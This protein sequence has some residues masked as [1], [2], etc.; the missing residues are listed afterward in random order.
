[1]ELYFEARKATWRKHPKS[2]LPPPTYS[3]SIFLIIFLFHFPNTTSSS[4]TFSPP[5]NYLIDCGS[6]EQT[7]LSDGRNFKSERDAASLLSAEDEVQAS[8]EFSAIA[9][10]AKAAASLFSSSSIN[11]SIVPPSSLPLYATVRIFSHESTYSFHISQPGPHWIRL[12]FYPVPDPTH[13]LTAA[14]FKVSAGNYVLL[15][16]F[17]AMT[18]AFREF[19]VNITGDRFSL[20]FKPKKKTVAFVNAIE[21]VSA[22]NTLIS[23]SVPAVYPP[24]QSVTGA[25][26]HALRVSYRL[27]VGGPTLVSEND[28]LYRV[29][30]TDATFNKFKEGSRNVSVPPETVEYQK[31]KGLTP[32]IAPSLVYASAQEMQ[33][34]L[35]MEPNF[36]LSWI[37][38]VDQGYSY[39]IRLHFCDIVSAA[40]NT[41]FFNVYINEIMAMESVDLS[42]LTG[43][44]S[45]AYYKDFVLHSMNITNNKIMVQV[46]CNS[47]FHSGIRDAILN[48]LEI[49]KMSNSANSLDGLF[50]VSGKYKGPS[51]QKAMK[52][53]AAAGL[54]MSLTA[55]V[56]LCVACVSWKK[57]PKG[58]EKRKSFS[59][60]LLPLQSSYSRSS[61]NRSTLS[62]FG[63][64]RSKSGYSSYISPSTVLFGRVFS[65]AEL[66]VATQS[67][68]EKAVIGVGGFGKVYL[69]VLE[70]GTKLAVK[71][72]N[73]SSEQGI[74]EFRTEIEM[75]SKLRHRH[76]VSLIGFC[77]EQ[78]EM[79]LVYEY[80]S[81]GPFRDHL[82]GSNL[83]KLS[84][85]QRLEICI[86]AAR[87]L[88]YLHTGA[89]QGIIHRDVKTTNILLDENFVAKVADFGL[90]K[91]APSLDQTHVST[92]V[93]GSFGYLDPEY[94]RR[95]QLTEKS[96][97]Y[98]FG[99][100]LFEAL[101]ARPVI[102]PKLPR[103]QVSL[104]EWAMH[105]HRKG[106]IET[107]IDPFI[108]EQISSESLKKFVEAAEKCMAEYGVDRP[109]MGDV[110]WNLEYSLQLHE[111][112][113]VEDVDNIKGQ[114]LISMEKKLNGNEQGNKTISVV[115]DV[116]DVS[117]DHSSI[118]VDG[119]GDHIPMFSQ[120]GNFQGR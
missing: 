113:V 102:D 104:A 44:L 56:L 90:S 120:M 75:L 24:G 76:L 116:E 93:K 47:N 89:A 17:S 19:L 117:E 78:S 7:R 20:V 87:G 45:T 22:P 114:S 63:S 50:T 100:V 80:M 51:G 106:S 49:M 99:V 66:Q 115:D 40:L 26:G 48:G 119:S 12:Y 43:A 18:F 15:E 16:N 9:N 2:K 32:L 6:S 64:R 55:M 34:P 96:D 71:R 54:A 67:F 3:F 111:A 13:N 36:N 5:D 92:A 29:W 107:I 68:T 84:W 95:Q 35:T 73:P 62:L 42:T 27:N 103:E 61:T 10:S 41:L 77:D 39:L 70:D 53:F 25:W 30:E 79:I 11:G 88:H 69:G 74:N 46:G 105:W 59:S 81:N 52:I 97:V 85:K 60:W 65:L 112:A 37:F 110:L 31:S 91:T 101:C 57:K 83:S 33:D 72:G 94:F 82:Y 108:S 1:M 118:T 23:D 109:S 4:S 28:T 8:V 98:S 38:N 14:I 21:L 86:G 58:W